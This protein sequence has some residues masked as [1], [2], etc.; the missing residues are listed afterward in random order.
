MFIGF[1]AFTKFWVNF[2]LGSR[3]H[4][5]AYRLVKPIRDVGDFS[6]K[7]VLRLTTDKFAAYQRVLAEMFF[8]IP[9]RYL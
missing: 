3:T 2:E 5:T 4:R 9:Y 1:E 7:R 6:Q 8:D